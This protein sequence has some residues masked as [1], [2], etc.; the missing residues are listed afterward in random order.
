[1]IFVRMC[2]ALVTQQYQEHQRQQQHH[3]HQVKQRKHQRPI[4]VETTDQ[5]QMRETMALKADIWHPVARW[6]RRPI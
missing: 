5:C 6:M 1:M 2:L 4:V 3:H